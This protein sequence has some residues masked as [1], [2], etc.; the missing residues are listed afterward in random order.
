[1][2]QFGLISLKKPIRLLFWHAGMSVYCG[3]DH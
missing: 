2:M 1:L 3:V